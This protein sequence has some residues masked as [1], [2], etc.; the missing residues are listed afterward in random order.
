M[1]LAV[2]NLPYQ[3]LFTNRLLK[4]PAYLGI[5][6]YSET[7]SDFYWEHLIPKLMTGRTGP[8]TVH[9]PYQN[10]DLSDP[11]MEYESVRDVYE[12]TFRLCKQFGA[13][14]CVCHPYAYYPIGAME[15]EESAA[16]KR[17]CLQRV[18]ELNRLA[19][20]WNVE[21]LVENMPDQD[22]LLSQTAFLELFNPVEDLAFLIDT[23]HA[24]IQSWDIELMFRTLG[25]RIRG[26]H[27]NDNFGDSDSHLMVDE[28]NFDWKK[29]FAGYAQYTPDA[30]L[31]MEYMK[32]TIDEL[33]ASAQRIKAYLEQK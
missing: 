3:G 20:R 4:L 7:G 2:S 32:G 26:Y 27:I 10:M 22:G 1:D 17:A 21:L 33:V 6:V 8:L 31:V 14:H 16:R 13:K 23:G 24:N 11:N 25:K 18:T 28:G 5:E 9:G 30:V 29:F 15:E 19:H 12:W